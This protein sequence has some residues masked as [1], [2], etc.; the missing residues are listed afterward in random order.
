MIRPCPKN[1]FLEKTKEISNYLSVR[2]KVKVITNVDRLLNVIR[3]YFELLLCFKQIDLGNFIVGIDGRKY[4]TVFGGHNKNGE[5][6]EL[7][8]DEVGA[9]LIRDII[10]DFKLTLTNETF[11]KYINL[12]NE[13][14]SSENI[15][16]LF[17]I[18]LLNAEGQA[19]NNQW[20]Y[21]LFDQDEE[22]A[23]KSIELR[24]DFIFKFLIKNSLTQKTS[25]IIVQSSI[26]DSY[27]FLVKAAVKTFIANNHFDKIFTFLYQELSNFDSISEDIELDDNRIVNFLLRQLL[28]NNNLFLIE[29]KDTINRYFEDYSEFLT[30]ENLEHFKS[31]LNTSLENFELTNTTIELVNPN[32]ENVDQNSITTEISFTLP[33]FKIDEEKTVAVDDR[34]TINASNVSNLFKDP[35]YIFLDSTELSIGPFPLTIFSDSI[36]NTNN[37]IRI[38]LKIKGFYHPD[39]NVIEDKLQPIV[40]NEAERQQGRNYPHKEYILNLLRKLKKERDSDFPFAINLEDISSELISNYYVAYYDS[41]GKRIYHKIHTITNFSTYVNAKERFLT[42]LSNLQLD[43]EIDDIHDLV[44][45]TEIDNTRSFND[46][47][48]RLLAITVKKPIELLGNH[49]YLW[50]NGEPVNEVKA[51]PLILNSMKPITEV[52]GIQMSRE[53]YAAN[54]SLDFHCSYT[55]SKGKLLKTCIELKRAQ[56]PDIAHGISYQLPQYIKAEGQG[57]GVFLVLWF[58]GAHFNTPLKY[59]SSHKLDVELKK[60]IPRG[61][62]IEIVIIDCSEKDS[63]SK[64]KKRVLPD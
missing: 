18:F 45:N 58:K 13:I 27:E 33:G 57:Y 11:S 55:T 14:I 4:R 21:L 42:Y 40:F 39:F 24:K 19:F 56:H 54:G 64:V 46:F 53:V 30:D 63:P 50:N 7:G 48:K 23:I 51:Q 62:R 35:V 16:V 2:K 1:Q 43:A 41:S 25:E 49:I 8:L 10:G 36:G 61:F 34:N 38:T 9:S 60:H 29:K 22:F 3:I 44:F 26:Y 32:F 17:R 59:E 37:S 20:L 6:V 28:A 12:A 52:K 47:I 15:D 31:D 5:P